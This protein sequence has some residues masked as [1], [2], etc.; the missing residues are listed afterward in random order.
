MLQTLPE[1]YKKYYFIHLIQQIAGN[2][3]VFNIQLIIKTHTYKLVSHL[4]NVLFPKM[5]RLF[6]NILIGET[7]NGNLC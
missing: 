3:Q 7:T 4:T 6:Y 1:L 5:L 2:H